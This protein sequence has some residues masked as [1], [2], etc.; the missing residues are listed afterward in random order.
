[1][2]N[3]ERKEELIAKIENINKELNEIEELL[4]KEYASKEL[5]EEQ[6]KYAIG[7]ILKKFNIPENKQG[8]LMF[9]ETIYMFS[10]YFERTK[11]DLA[12][13]Y[14]I[15]A[16]KFK[17]EPQ[18]IIASMEN[19]L[20]SG[21]VV[22]SNASKSLWYFINEVTNYYLER[23]ERIFG[24]KNKIANIKKS[25]ERL[26]KEDEYYIVKTKKL[27]QTP[28]DIEKTIDKYLY[29]EGIHK[30]LPEYSFL[31]QVIVLYLINPNMSR[32]EDIYT[33]VST[34]QGETMYNINNDIKLILDY[35]KV[36]HNIDQKSNEGFDEI[37]VVKLIQ[38]ICSRYKENYYLE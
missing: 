33:E 26:L 38:R 15:I 16:K 20:S 32:I 6:E 7:K 18:I 24:H 23:K 12:E 36:Q 34:K 31:K 21:E 2:E 5:T 22:N 37:T 29:D 1:M 17:T 30:Y 9:Q 19:V 3:T 11:K 27:K 28:L 13:I 10:K 8:F 35:L 25:L 14:K 4:N